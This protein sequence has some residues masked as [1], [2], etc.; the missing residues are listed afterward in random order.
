MDEEGNDLVMSSRQQEKGG[1]ELYSSVLSPRDQSSM[2]SDKRFPLSCL[3]PS[4][5]WPC[6]DARFLSLP[7]GLIVRA[8]GLW[9]PPR[10]D[11]KAKGINVLTT[12][13]PS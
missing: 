6:P 3:S 1:P 7:H 4:R 2:W 12:T 10:Q 13:I 11:L 8:F 9:V 5:G